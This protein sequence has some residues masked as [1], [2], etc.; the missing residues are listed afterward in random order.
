MMRESLLQAIRG[1][2]RTERA[3]LACKGV[4]DLRAV[5]MS[6]P[7]QVRIELKYQ[8]KDVFAYVVLPKE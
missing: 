6:E 7:N 4:S 1:L 2:G 8:G 5:A 3:L